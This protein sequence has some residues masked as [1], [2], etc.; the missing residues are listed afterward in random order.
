MRI[1]VTGGAGFIG[2]HLIRK[3]REQ[4]HDVD[5]IDNHSTC[6][7]VSKRRE[8]ELEKDKNVEV[9]G[10]DIKATYGVLDSLE[11][12]NRAKGTIKEGEPAVDAIVHL[13]APISVVESIR[14]PGKYADEIYKGTISV[15]DAA[16]AKGVKRVILAS[17]AAVYGNP[18]KMPITEY[19]KT[20]PLSPYAISKRAA[21]NYAHMAAK[22][23]GLETVILRF[24]NVYGPDQD[25]TSPYCG[26]IS[27]FML[28]AKEKKSFAIFGDGSQTRDFVY[29]GD[30]CDAIIAA[31]LA[32]VEPGLVLNIGSGTE[33]SILELSHKIAKIT[34]VQHEIDKKDA[35]KGDILRS[36]AAVERAKKHIGFEPKV[37]LDEGLK[38]TWEYFNAHYKPS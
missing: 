34:G 14:D 20:E 6:P 8:R 1:F 36:L 26:V 24:F 30:V 4:K 2:S 19:I 28:Q 23:D 10:M 35:R 9:W 25:P 21:E 29:V 12:R 31:L 5:A 17:T 3:L 7:A 18:E 16:K 15:I 13:A 11:K 32:K 27:N 33:T 37:S 22:N 38:T